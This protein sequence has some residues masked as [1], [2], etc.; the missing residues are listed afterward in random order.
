LFPFSRAPQ[1]EFFP[2][3]Y[4]LAAMNS[5]GAIWGRVRDYASGLMSLRHLGPRRQGAVNGG[6]RLWIAK[7]PWIVSARL[8]RAQFSFL[9]ERKTTEVI[10]VLITANGHIIFDERIYQKKNNMSAINMMAKE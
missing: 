2:P 6:L 5:G 3:N 4:W 1:L 10:T 8:T 7:C 9:Q